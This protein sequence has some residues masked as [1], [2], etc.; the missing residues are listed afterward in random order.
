MPVKGIHYYVK[1][2]EC[3]KKGLYRRRETDWLDRIYSYT[4][5]I[6]YCRFCHYRDYDTKYYDQAYSDTFTRN[7]LCK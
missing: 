4:Y 7:K 6:L 2:P 1:C 5:M 3:G